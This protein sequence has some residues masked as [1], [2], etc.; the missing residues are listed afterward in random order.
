MLLQRPENAKATLTP[1]VWD[2]CNVVLNLVLLGGAIPQAPEDLTAARQDVMERAVEFMDSQRKL[3][4]R[5]PEGSLDA[6]GYKALPELRRV[7]ENAPLAPVPGSAMWDVPFPGLG[8][9]QTESQEISY[10]KWDEEYLERIFTVTCEVI[11]ELGIGRD[12]WRAV[13]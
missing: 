5:R 12:G 13:R 6:S 3:Y 9:I 8:F 10:Y 4:A 7:L 2:T 1:W 11:E